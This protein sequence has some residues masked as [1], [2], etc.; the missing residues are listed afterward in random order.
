ITVSAPMTPVD[1]EARAIGGVV[2]PAPGTATRDLNKL[3]YAKRTAAALGYI[4]LSN[5]DRLS[6][7]GFSKSGLQRFSAARGKGHAVK[8]L[9]FIAGIKA[10]GATDLDLMCRQYASQARFPGLLFILSDFLVEGGGTEGL[11]ALQAAGHEVNVIHILA[12]AEVHPEL[13]LIGDLRLR[14][15]ETGATQEVSID[16]GVLD[17]YRE[18]FEAWQQGIEMF[19]RKRGIN[20]VQVTTDQPFEDLV[21]HYL[22]RR[23]ILS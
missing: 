21:L 22:R 2:A 3:I 4:A 11:R 13:A 6:V 9:R 10:E 15:V 16:G 20:Y 17:L 8:L 19:C 12:P 1:S 7:T 18:K 14:D 23:G 5:L